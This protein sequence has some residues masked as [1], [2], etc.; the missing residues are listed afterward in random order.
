M[1]LWRGRV[2][3]RRDCLGDAAQHLVRWYTTAGTTWLGKRVIPWA[4]RMEVDLAA[5]R[6]RSLGYRWGSCGRDG[7]VNIHWATMQLSPDLIDYVL[8]HEL[9]HVRHRDHG[10]A[11]WTTVERAM[12]DAAG[13][14]L[15]L[16]KAGA[17][18]W[19]PQS[20]LDL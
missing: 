6:V 15:R 10:A 2:E 1:R 3:L 18:L 8:V 16:R 12:P 14:R 20:A 4:Q 11:F 13:R 9:A 19:L 7:A 5:L 17:D